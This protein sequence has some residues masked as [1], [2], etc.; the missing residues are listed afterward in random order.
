MRVC[1]VPCAIS[2]PNSTWFLNS[3]HQQIR[4]LQLRE[5]NSYLEC[6]RAAHSEL[7]E[8][9]EFP[10]LLPFLLSH[11][12]LPALQQALAFFEESDTSIERTLRKSGFG[13]I[14]LWTL[15]VLL[16]LWCGGAEEYDC[17]QWEHWDD[18]RN[19]FLSREANSQWHCLCLSCMSIYIVQQSGEMS[20]APHGIVCLL[21]T[22][23]A[24]F[25]VTEIVSSRD[26]KV[27]NC[28]FSSSGSFWFSIFLQIMQFPSSHVVSQK[29]DCSGLK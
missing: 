2:F 12:C 22:G 18:E 1:H 21:K 23:K 16:S 17:S 10:L 15:V 4:R 19:V 13:E 20:H 6:Y 27:V 29:R 8:F 5:A 9:Y 26:S 14:S 3:T 24:S 28:F 11:R 25:L 7:H